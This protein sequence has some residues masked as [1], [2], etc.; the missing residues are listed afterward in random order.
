MRFG[1]PSR[2][3]RNPSGGLGHGGSI[4]AYHDSERANGVGRIPSITS[5]AAERT[6]DSRHQCSRFARSN[7]AIGAV[8]RRAVLRKSNHHAPSPG[9]CARGVGGGPRCMGASAE[10]NAE[11][12]SNAP[13]QQGSGCGGS[14]PAA[15]RETPPPQLRGHSGQICHADAANPRPARLLPPER[16]VTL[17]CRFHDPQSW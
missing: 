10:R 2:T 1:T 4:P 6:E 8:A 3:D 5:V 17:R 12:K 9:G 11:P 14:M 16:T 13:P 15:M 7:R